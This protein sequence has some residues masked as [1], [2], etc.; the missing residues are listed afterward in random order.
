MNKYK[1]ILWKII[2]II[3]LVNIALWN[4][5]SVTMFQAHITPDMHQKNSIIITSLFC[6]VILRIIKS[7][8]LAFLLVIITDLTLIFIAI[9]ETG[10][11]EKTFILTMSNLVSTPVA[12]FIL[13]SIIVFVLDWRMRYKKIQVIQI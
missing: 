2:V 4:I 9:L 11:L 3:A 12:L 10:F 13:C 7:Y 8:K 6:G 1:F 5:L